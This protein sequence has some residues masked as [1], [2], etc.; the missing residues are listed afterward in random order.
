[1]NKMNGDLILEDGAHPD[2]PEERATMEAMRK[3]EEEAAQKY[4]LIEQ[5]GE[6]G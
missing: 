4:G 5:D 3:A 1:M 6:E 2:N